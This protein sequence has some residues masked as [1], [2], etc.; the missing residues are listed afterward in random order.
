[1]G[2]AY[3]IGASWGA[4]YDHPGLFEITGGTK[5]ASTVETIKAIR[6]EV[7]RIRTTDHPARSISPLTAEQ[8][9]EKSTAERPS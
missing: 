1:M 9:A 4:G 2:N 6:E 8:I 5:S 7:E 3:D